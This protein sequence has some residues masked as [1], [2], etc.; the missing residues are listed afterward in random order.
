MPA[1]LPYTSARHASAGIL[2]AAL[3]SVAGCATAPPKEYA[4]KGRQYAIGKDVA[5]LEQETS[6]LH[7]VYYRAVGICGVQVPDLTGDGKLQR[8]AWAWQLPFTIRPGA[9]AA[10]KAKFPYTATGTVIANVAPDR[11]FIGGP[12]D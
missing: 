7:V 3:V 1:R 5:C 4:F 2:L 11:T 12:Y 6:D 8:E 9:D 10:I